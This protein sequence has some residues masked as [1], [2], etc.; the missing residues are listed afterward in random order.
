[1]KLQLFFL[2]AIL[3]LVAADAPVKLEGAKEL[4]DKLYGPGAFAQLQKKKQ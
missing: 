4:L 2:F 1:M 3:G